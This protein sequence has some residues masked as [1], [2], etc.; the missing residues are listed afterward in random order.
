MHT[1]IDLNDISDSARQGWRKKNDKKSKLLWINIDRRLQFKVYI[2]KVVV[3]SKLVIKV[4]RGLG[5]TIR[6][7]KNLTLRSMYLE[8]IITVMEYG[9]EVWPNNDVS[10]FE[11]LESI[12]YETLKKVS[13]VYNG[14]ASYVL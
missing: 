13:W 12:H 14:T 9:C 6:G 8:C 11:K 10:Q 7:V 3:K 4:V 2:R 5:G 1:E